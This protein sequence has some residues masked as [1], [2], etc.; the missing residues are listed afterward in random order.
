MDWESLGK[1][2]ATFE[3]DGKSE[4]EELYLYVK[5]IAGVPFYAVRLSPNPQYNSTYNVETRVINRNDIRGR[6]EIEGTIYRFNL[7]CIGINFQD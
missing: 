4:N 1:V 5:I 2:T 3:K 7:P 6:V